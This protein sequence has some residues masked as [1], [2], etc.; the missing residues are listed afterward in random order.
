MQVLKY[1]RLLYYGNYDIE[2]AVAFFSRRDIPLDSSLR[3]LLDKS[4]LR[5]SGVGVGERSEVDKT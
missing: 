3:G 1:E 2:T 4:L 5:L